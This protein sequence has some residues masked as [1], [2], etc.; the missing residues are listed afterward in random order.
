MVGFIFQGFNLVGNLSVLRNV[1]I[2]RLS[3]KASW[4]IAFTGGIVASRSRPW[5]RSGSWRRPSAG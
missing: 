4:D 3:E 2:G 5:Q 1:L